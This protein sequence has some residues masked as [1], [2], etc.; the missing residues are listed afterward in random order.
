MIDPGRIIEVARTELGTPFHHQGR[1]SRVGIDCIG[2]LVIIAR[3]LGIQHTDRT[4][5]P[6]RGTEMNLRRGLEGA[7]LIQVDVA[8]YDEAQVG[9]ILMF[10][11]RYPNKP[12]HV[13]IKSDKG[14]I[15]TYANVNRVVEH[16]IND[17]WKDRVC[18]VWRFPGVEILG[19]DD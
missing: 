15:H 6:R 7:G 17:W 4:D 18:G 11:I 13:G 16:G 12:Q 9:D 8:G 2:L 3:T 14:M 10:W 1:C 19:G 5:Y